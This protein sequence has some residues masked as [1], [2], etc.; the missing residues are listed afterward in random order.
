MVAPAGACSNHRRHCQWQDA[1][2]QHPSPVPCP[3]CI[4]GQDFL[5]WLSRKSCL[6]GSE[7]DGHHQKF[8]CEQVSFYTS[9]EENGALQG[10]T[11]VAFLLTGMRSSL[12]PVDVPSA[13]GASFCKGAI[14]D[15]DARADDLGELVKLQVWL[16]DKTSQVCFRPLLLALPPGLHCCC[17]SSTDSG[18]AHTTQRGSQRNT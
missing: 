18:C 9:R 6:C 11:H 15:Y 7:L 8:C 17:C 4:S 13:T 10:A 5:K 14:T 3:A 1:T 2:S 12:G 16:V